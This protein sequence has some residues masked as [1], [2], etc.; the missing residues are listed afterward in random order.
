VT[1]FDFASF[2][3][4]YKSKAQDQ[5]FSRGNTM[6]VKK[7]WLITFSPTRT[8][9]HAVEAIASGLPVIP[10]ENM[11]LTYSGA[12]SVRWFAADELVIIG[13]PVYAGR[14]APLA[15][16]RL[17]MLRGHNTPTVIT[18]TYGNRDFEDALIELNDIALQA[19]F[20]PVAACTFIGEHSFSGPATPI[21]AGRPDSVDLAT[22]K[23]FG[24][25]IG[26]KLA[27]LEEP[28]IIRCP[29]VPGKRPYKEGMGPM[30]FTPGLLKSRCTQCAACLP[31]CPTGALSLESRIE[32]DGDLCIFCC[33]CI[34]VCPEGA[35]QIDAAPLIQK[36]QWLYE[37][38]A[39]RKEPELYL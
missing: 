25:K 8:S 23:A 12:V 9:Q 2:F 26:E 11:D 4:V 39:R 17:G 5:T 36:R 35:L 38:C 34:K 37:H 15:V 32:V 21:A 18:V 24:L 6:Q 13:V 19:A 27:R 29:E 1:F 31:V 14:V 7:I 20:L 16:K 30:P 10:M 33:A 28:G 22:T 3:L